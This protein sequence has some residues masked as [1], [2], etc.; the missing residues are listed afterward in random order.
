VKKLLAAIPQIS[1]A[2]VYQH[3]LEG[4]PL[5]FKLQVI[6]TIAN[7][8]H[9]AKKHFSVRS[10]F[11]KLMDAIDALLDSIIDA[12]GGAEGVIKEFKDT[13]GSLA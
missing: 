5:N 12:A 6:N 4:R 11:K 9:M 1:Q 8:L 10:S 7:Q 2:K 3:G 13:L